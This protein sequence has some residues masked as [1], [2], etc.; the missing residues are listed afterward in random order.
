VILDSH[1]TT[2]TDAL[3][4]RQALASLPEDVQALLSRLY[5][6]DR[7]HAEVAVEIGRSTAYVLRT[8][9]QALMWL[10]SKFDND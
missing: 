10:R 8:E 5:F 9:R 7:T 2:V 1:E 4:L 3:G 6:D